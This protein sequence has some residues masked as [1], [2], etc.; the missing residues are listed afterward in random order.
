M[1]INISLLLILKW[2]REAGGKCR[3][4]VYIA[5]NFF[6]NKIKW[7]NLASRHESNFSDLIDYVI[8]L[9]NNLVHCDVLDLRQVIMNTV[10]SSNN[11]LIFSFS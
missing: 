7:Q 8:I 4:I 10:L 11:F 5:I 1:R 3:E 2:Q 9:L 6:N